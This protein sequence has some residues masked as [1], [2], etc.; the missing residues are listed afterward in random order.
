MSSMRSNQLRACSRILP[1]GSARSCHESWHGVA[2]ESLAWAR[3]STCV[4]V[5]GTSSPTCST[6]PGA[7][8]LGRWRRL[9]RCYEGTEASARAWLEVAS[10]GYLAWRAIA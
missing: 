4:T 6:R 9:S 3:S 1:H 5:N 8:E 10:V 2:R 7:G